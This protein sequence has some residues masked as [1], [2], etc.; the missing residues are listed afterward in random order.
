MTQQLRIKG[1]HCCGPG[2]T[3]GWGISTCGGR[4]PPLPIYPSCRRI[5]RTGASQAAR[6]DGTRLAWL[7]GPPYLTAPSPPGAPPSHQLCSL[8]PSLC[9]PG[10]WKDAGNLPSH[11]PRA[12]AAFRVWGLPWVLTET[13][14]WGSRRDTGKSQPLEAS[15]PLLRKGTVWRGGS[16]PGAAP[17]PRLPFPSLERR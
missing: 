7:P 10:S 5:K 14:V 16:F 8:T 6:S 17:S 15:V 9:L 13:R 1:C 4:A 11:L 2:W 12:V 3:P